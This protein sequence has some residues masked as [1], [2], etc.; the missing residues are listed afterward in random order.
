MK[1]KPPSEKELIYAEE[2]MEKQFF[3][4]FTVRDEANALVV[5]CFRNGPIE[6]YHANDRPIGQKEMKRIM[7][8]AC[9]NLEKYLSLKNENAIKYKGAMMLYNILF[10][11]GWER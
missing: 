4:S 11:G 8:Y 2:Q 3:S 9:R 7:L 5:L 10:C 6:D 1:R